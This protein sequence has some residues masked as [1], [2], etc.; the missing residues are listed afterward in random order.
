MAAPPASLTTEP[1]I[2]RPLIP[3]WQTTTLPRTSKPASEPSSHAAVISSPLPPGKTSGSIFFAGKSFVW[4][5]DSPLST[6]PFP[7]ITSATILLSIVLA[8]TVRTH[9][10]SLT[11]VSFPG[12]SFPAD[13][14][15]NIP[16]DIAVKVLIAI[17][18]S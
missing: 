13:A 5:N 4:F 15:I 18:S 17:G 12:P 1:F 6:F 11:T 14:L 9:G 10:A 7:S 16:F 3:L 8:A 2:T